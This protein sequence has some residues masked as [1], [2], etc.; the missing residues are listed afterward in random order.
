MV[1]TGAPLRCRR[2]TPPE[3]LMTDIVFVAF[4]VALFALAIAY[5]RACDRL[6]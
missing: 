6:R 5:V 4:T 3:E 2:T 1:R